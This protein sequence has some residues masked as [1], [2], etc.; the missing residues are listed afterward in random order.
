MILYTLCLHPLLRTPEDNLPGIRLG[1]STRSPPVDAYADDV[2]VLVTQPR[3]FA[4]IHE[5]VRCY[6]KATGAN[7]N[8]QKWKALPMG[9]GGS[10][11]LNLELSLTT[12]LRP[13]GSNMEPP[14][15][16]R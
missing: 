3:D 14:L 13:W 2:T 10:Q 16:N 1:R 4:I 7:L 6:E 15:Q 12:M 5:A 9:G 8:S 11:Q